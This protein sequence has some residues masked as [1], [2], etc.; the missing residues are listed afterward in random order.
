MQCQI[1]YGDRSR[2][3]NI[4]DYNG[5]IKWHIQLIKRMGQS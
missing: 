2:R 5:E 3:Q 1:N 4:I